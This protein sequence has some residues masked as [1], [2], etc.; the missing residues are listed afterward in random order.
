[1]VDGLGRMPG[2]GSPARAWSGAASIMLAAD[3]YASVLPE[4]LADSAGA[5]ARLVLAHAT[6]NPAGDAKGRPPAPAAEAGMYL[7]DRLRFASTF[8]PR[9]EWVSPGHL[10]AIVAAPDGTDVVGWMWY[11]AVV[12]G[13]EDDGSV[14]LWE[15]AHGEV[16]AQPGASYREQDPGSRA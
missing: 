9:A 10:V 11:D 8:S 12:L 1:M 4:P 14:R 5:T 15:P 13:T 2:D 16:V 3:T 6:A 7:G